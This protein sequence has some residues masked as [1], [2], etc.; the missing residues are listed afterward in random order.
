MSRQTCGRTTACVKCCVG[1]VFNNLENHRINLALH[2]ITFIHISVGQWQVI[3]VYSA[4][5]TPI[6]KTLSQCVNMLQNKEILYQL[7][8]ST[9]L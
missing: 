4:L 5:C 2:L 7:S 1:C 8:R 6:A 9:Q 3:S